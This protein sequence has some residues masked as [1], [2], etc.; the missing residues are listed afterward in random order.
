MMPLIGVTACWN[1]GA[2]AEFHSANHPY[3][4]AVLRSGCGIPVLIP[5]LGADLP[6]DA[7][8]ERLDGLMVT[9][10]RSNVDP[11]EYG[12]APAPASELDPRRDATTLPLIRAA[13]R[14][15]LPVL[16]ICRGLQEMNVA[17]GGTLHQ[18]VHEVPGRLDH[19]DQA[20]E[21]RA[22]KWGPRHDVTLAQGGR[23]A[24]LMGGAA[25]LQVNS[26]HWQAI[27]RL[28]P[29]LAV[30]ATAPDGTIEAVRATEAAGFNLAVQWHPETG[31]D[32]QELS[33][34]LF[35]AFGAAARERASLQRA[36]T[37]AA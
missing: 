7:L 24:Q 3:V 14:S 28:A 19:R 25:T 34:R 12:G 18:R 33:R 22:Q 26:L 23:I 35:A 32:D 20:D 9:G 13:L 37:R 5:A 8:I 10:S 30:E 6:V 16:A 29:G 27:D 21:T 1:V 4:Q 31:L 15:G 2:E 17:L 36:G 11:A